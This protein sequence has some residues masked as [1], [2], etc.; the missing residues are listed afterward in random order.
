MGSWEELLA[1]VFCYRQQQK[2]FLIMEFN[3]QTLIGLY[4]KEKQN[5]DTMYEHESRTPG[6]EGIKSDNPCC[7]EFRH[8]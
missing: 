8:L 6:T 7:V 5:P 3:L 4:L 2:T 1:P